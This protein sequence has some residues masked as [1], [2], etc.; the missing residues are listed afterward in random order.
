M[1]HGVKTNEAINNPPS[2]TLNTR[3][4]GNMLGCYFCSDI[5]APGNV[6]I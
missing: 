1:R 2:N 5:V 3:V 4:P 6:G